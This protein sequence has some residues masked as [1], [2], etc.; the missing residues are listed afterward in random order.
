M[1]GTL[2]GDLRRRFRE[3]SRIRLDEMASLLATLERDPRD[4]ESLRNLA[5]H[6]HGLA[7]MGGTYGFPRVSELGDEA[8][9][10]L[11]PLVKRSAAPGPSLVARWKEILGEM[12][13]ELEET[14][15]P[16]A[17]SQAAARPFEVVLIES[18]SALAASIAEALKREEMSVRVCA[19]WSEAA[20]YEGVDA[21]IVVGDTEEFAE[22][23]RAIRSGADVFVAK[24]VDVDALVQRVGALRERKEHPPRRI[25]AVEDD[26]TTAVLIRGMLAA[27]GYEVEVCV[28]PAEFERTLLA[29][30]PDLVLMDVQ[31][32][33]DVSGHDLVRY[34][35][36]S[37]RFS[38]LP[39]I[40]VTSD[41][42]R[43]AILDGAS[44]GADVLVTKPVDWDVL[45]SHIAARLE[46]ATVVRELTERD[47]LTGV[48]TRGAFDTRARHRAEN[49]NSA[50]LVLLDLD[51]FKE[52]NDTRGH[53]AG[54]RVLAA[55]GAVLRRHLRQTD[56]V[57]RYGGE[58]FALL[59]EDL[60]VPTA[61]SLCERLLADLSSTIDVTFSA[62]VAP[63]D[64]SFEEAFR[65][66]DLALY[67]AKRGGRARVMV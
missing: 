55:T 6:F 57:A 37:E 29:F 46:R 40:I 43:R 32:A 38:T 25:L 42:E 31:L 64:G 61:V 13:R 20:A 35:R 60:S 63:L 39:V 7:G 53:V 33:S 23:V 66:A 59:L 28:A 8:E 49:G 56:V 5:K 50:V 67:E 17:V 3:T 58:E 24:P 51:H 45:L 15:S 11:L 19:S 41:S 65:R 21:T 47:P 18:D 16:A 26:P 27:A 48:L 44:A 54:D 36:R 1:T 30:G 14:G 62:G 10:E 34:V 22:K 2:L 12:R 4:A 9:A 52:I